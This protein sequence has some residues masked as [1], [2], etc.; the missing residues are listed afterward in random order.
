M[1]DEV[2]CPS[3]LT[4]RVRALKVKE[5]RLFQDPKL[6]K[7]GG[8][9]L[10]IVKRCWE[11]T[12]DPGPYSF[13]GGEINWSQLLEGDAAYL[14]FRVRALTYGEQYDITVQCAACNRAIDHTVDLLEDLRLQELPKS[15]YS[16][17][18]HDEPI[19]VKAP[20]GRAVQFR[21]L[22]MSDQRSIDMLQNTRQ[23]TPAN[24]R[25]AVRLIAV[26][27]VGEHSG[28]KIRWIED[29]TSGDA[30]ELRDAVEAYDCGVDTALELTCPHCYFDQEQDLP[31]VG[32]FFQRRSR[33]KKRREQLAAVQN[34]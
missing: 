18:G 24:A 14:F 6:L 32:S 33:K 22:R 28:P 10:E 9:M 12:I 31:L 16:A 1:S 20:D 5:E 21:L 27:G 26:E 19:S 34:G 15:A 11:E 7:S 3:G 2:K 23:L 4:G 13:P 8:L 29:L 17:V 30:E 25:L